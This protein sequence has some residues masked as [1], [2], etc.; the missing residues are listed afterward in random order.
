MNR[1]SF[2]YLHSPTNLSKDITELQ[3]R[4][5]SQLASSFLK[6]PSDAY[7]INQTR[8]SV[9]IAPFGTGGA[10]APSPRDPAPSK[11]LFKFREIV[12]QD[13]KQKFDNK[14]DVNSNQKYITLPVKLPSRKNILS[15]TSDYNL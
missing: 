13:F 15:T 12:A 4:K 7:L 11:I 10:G 3:S 8:N 2:I 6:S 9:A 1:S 5:Y 14:F